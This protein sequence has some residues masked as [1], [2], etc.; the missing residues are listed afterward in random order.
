M[1]LNLKSNL[2]DFFNLTKLNLAMLTLK[3]LYMQE[4]IG[5]K[6]KTGKKEY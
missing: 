1:K 6:I 4:I 3:Q 2:I 5:A